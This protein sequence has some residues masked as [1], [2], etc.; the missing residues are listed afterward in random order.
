[1]N[2]REKVTHIWIELAKGI[3][4]KRG[5]SCHNNGDVKLVSV[6]SY[7]TMKVILILL[8]LSTLVRNEKL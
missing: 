7:M 4:E 6:I 3:V 1:M 5:R 8:L 2:S